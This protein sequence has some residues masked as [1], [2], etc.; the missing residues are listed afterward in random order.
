MNWIT[1][2]S[3]YQRGAVLLL[4]GLVALAGW[5][6]FQN[7]P[8]DAIPDVTNVQ[9]QINT[10]VAG[11]APE[12]TER[13]VTFPIETAMR[14][15]PG[16]TQVRSLTRFN[17]SQVTVIF[18]EDVDI[19]RARQ[20]VSERLQQAAG[21]LP[22]GVQ[23]QPGPISSGLGEIIHYGL[24]AEQ[25]AE[26]A[27]RE[28][29]LM[30]LRSLQEWFVKPR[31][32]T[33]KGVADV[34]ALGGFERQFHVQPDIR[35]LA[36]YGL[37]F[38]DLID[39]LERANQNVGGGYVQQTGEQFLIQAVG[40][41]RTT[42]DIREVPIRTL[43]TLKTLTIGDVA[44]VTLAT[45]LRSGAA[46]I[47]GKEAVIGTVMM[48]MG[49]NSRTVAVRAAARLREIQKD[50][51]PGYRLEILYD[52]SELVS[53]TLGTVEHNLLTGA[54][55]VVVILALLLGNVRAALVTALT[56]PL[57]L[58]MAFIGMKYFGISGNLMSLGALD[59]GIVV[60]ATVIVLDHCVRVV[61]D[62]RCELGRALSGKELKDAIIEAT[63]HIRSAAGF[64]QIIIVTVFLPVFALVGVEGKMFRP[65]AITFILAVLAALVLSF[66]FV[67]ALAS[68]LLDGSTEDVKPW[69]M[70]QAER[71]YEPL[72]A[73]VM[74]KRKLTV[75][76]GVAAAALGVGLFL[77]LGGEFLPQLDEGSFLI[78]GTR[79]VN[80]SL[81]QSLVIQS[82]T[83]AIVSQFPEV[84]YTFSK[85]G[86]SEIANDPMGVHQ[87]DNYVMFKP[88]KD[89]PKING[90]RR[91]KSELAQA[92]FEKLSAELPGQSVLPSQPIQM[93][94]NDLLEGSKADVS[95]KVFG[96]DMDELSRITK[97]V[98]AV[99]EKVRGAG[100]VETEL[101]GTSPLL[102]IRPKEGILRQLGVSTIEVLEA[103]GIALGGQ[104]AGYFYEGARRFPILVRLKE[105]QRSD[106][107]LIRNLPVG[108]GANATWPLS[109][110]ADIA[111]ERTYGT[112]MRENGKRRAAVMINPR[113]R[114]TESFVLEAQREV[115]RQVKLPLGYY[116]E[117]GGTFKNLQQARSRLLVLAPLAI[118]LALMMIYAAFNNAYQTA[119]ISLGVP[120]ALV[121]GVIGLMANGLPFSISAGVGFIAL[122]GIAVLN[123]VVLMSYFN[124]LRR[125]GKR[126]E[127]LVK[128]GALLRLRPVLMTALV[129]IFGFLPMM[130]S[131][132]VGS[133]VQKPLAAVVIGG[134]FSSTLLTLA[135]LPALYLLMEDKM[136]ERAV[137]I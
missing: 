32:L 99:V 40:L 7:L 1:R 11:F 118:L 82:K 51:P 111:F 16:V 54:C 80:V 93:R 55:L 62:R 124:D 122:S 35:K 23:P 52:R 94:F 88:L 75:A 92:M 44:D 58:L 114:D 10:S 47:R 48:L 63:L 8:I 107:E 79:P 46:L 95:V 13:N 106:L 61:A 105:E 77:R 9:V 115:E 73:F 86:T 26:G 131:S 113:G 85:L 133:E 68:I 112:I 6:T 83:E 29:Q 33:V 49:E 136:G 66:T 20:L 43:E 134:I 30:E 17:L 135:V 38:K 121:G 50:L 97:E 123:G 5:I 137:E 129:D 103:V 130:M 126:G 59:F 87:A 120:M 74:R 102:R 91:T 98:A 28:A 110:A 117:W 89:W 34:N 39:A 71:A 14:G 101:Q 67:P 21:N 41:F 56:I 53:A 45:E 72:L 96:D 81:D 12:E 3:V 70:R 15:L 78:Q 69:L 84:A 119:L 109:K 128:E 104:Q 108:I 18:E 22:P 2:F 25:T 76:L 125:E 90:R 65:M 19:Y 27:A 37:H 132:G 127:A 36:S 4:T 64:G 42:Q 60:D 57:S 100:E 116:V 24:E 31:L